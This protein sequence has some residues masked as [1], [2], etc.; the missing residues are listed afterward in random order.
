[1]RTAKIVP[2]LRLSARQISLA[3]KDVCGK[4]TPFLFS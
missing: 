1:M 4:P 2:D 3:K